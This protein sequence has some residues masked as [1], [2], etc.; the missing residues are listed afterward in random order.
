MM[1]YFVIEFSV[2]D[3]TAVKAAAQREEH[4]VFNAAFKSS[5]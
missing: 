2:V 5:L 4:T 1:L 3:N